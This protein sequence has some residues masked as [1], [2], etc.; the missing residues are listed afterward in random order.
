MSFINKFEQPE[1][2]QLDPSRNASEAR[3]VGVAKTLQ[4]KWKSTK[5][6]IYTN[7]LEIAQSLLGFF[8]GI[9]FI[10]NTTISAIVFVK[11]M[12]YP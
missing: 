11:L 12:K 4:N 6:T 2:A 3:F 9:I 7:S 8:A 5:I 10:R 1:L